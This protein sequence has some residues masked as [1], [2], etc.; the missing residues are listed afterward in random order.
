M[1]LLIIFLG[2]FFGN[3]SAMGETRIN[4]PVV[5]VPDFKGSVSNESDAREN[6]ANEAE[7]KIPDFKGSESIVPD[8]REPEINEPDV[9]EIEENKP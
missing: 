8:S 3:L 2:I 7:G 1:K 5:N 6:S 9:R 4:E